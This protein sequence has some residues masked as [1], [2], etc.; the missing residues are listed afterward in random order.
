MIHLVWLGILGLLWGSPSY[1]ACTG[2]SPTWTSTAD[3][4]SVASC[5]SSATAGDTINVSAGTATWASTITITKGMYLTG[6]GVGS[7]VITVSGLSDGPIE[8]NPDSTAIA[9]NG[10]FELSGFEFNLSS[11]SAGLSMN[12][13]SATQN[14][15]TRIRIHHNYW[16]NS[17]FGSQWHWLGQLY[18]VFDH[19]QIDGSG[20]ITPYSTDDGTSAWTNLTYAFGTANVMVFEDNTWNRANT[21]WYII[22]GGVGGRYVI[23]YNTIDMVRSAQ[24]L[25]DAHGNQTGANLATMGLEIYRNT[26]TGTPANNNFLSIRGG[27]GMV[28]DNTLLSTTTEM[29]VRE[30]YADSNNPPASGPGGQSQHVS[31]T[32]AF[33]NLGGSTRIDLDEQDD[34]CGVIAENAQ[35]YNQAT[36]FTGATGVGRGTLAAKPATCTTGVGYWATDQGSW[37]T[38]VGGTQGLFYKCTSMNTWTLYYTPLAYPHTLIAGVSTVPTIGL[39]G[40]VNL[41]GGTRLQ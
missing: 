25:F 1:A 21:D 31:D 3:R 8:Y 23:R 7:T 13:P 38:N 39:H 19:N 12:G 34:C 28:F 5:I 6:A 4:T 20:I 40:G 17:A 11:N 10:A 24:P 33:N 32:Y 41:S 14:P 16:R 37:N 9:A 36:S 26:I 30:E 27:K 18:G 2:S 35:F 29:I 22:E 15:Q